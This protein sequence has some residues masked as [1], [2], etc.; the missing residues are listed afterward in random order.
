M[1]QLCSLSCHLYWV[2]VSRAGWRGGAEREKQ[3]FL[4]EG[5][6][7]CLSLALAPTLHGIFCLTLAALA[8]CSLGPAASCCFVSLWTGYQDPG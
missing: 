3:Q 5:L 4:P 6:V 1:S 2:W 8:V 7:K